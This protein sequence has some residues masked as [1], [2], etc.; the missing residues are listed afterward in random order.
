MKVGKLGHDPVEGVAK[1]GEEDHLAAARLA[2]Q[3]RRPGADALQ[4]GRDRAS[5]IAARL[6]EE[7]GPMA[8]LE[9]T[10]SQV[11]LQGPDLAADGGLGQVQLL[12][13]LGEALEPGRRLEGEEA[14]QGR[15]VPAQLIHNSK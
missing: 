7:H 2:A 14:G 1:L 4:P 11:L 5:E 3:V 15:K 6:G 13:G 12:G 10:D 8:A 9:E